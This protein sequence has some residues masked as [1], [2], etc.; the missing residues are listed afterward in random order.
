[1]LNAG[2]SLV[3]GFLAGSTINTLAQHCKENTASQNL[4]F[5][6]YDFYKF[7]PNP[8]TSLANVI[9]KI[10]VVNNIFGESPIQYVP[11]QGF[12][13]ARGKI[14][15]I[16]INVTWT[17]SSLYDFLLC[18]GQCA[19]HVFNQTLH[20]K[21]LDHYQLFCQKILHCPEW[22]TLFSVLEV[23]LREDPALAKWLQKRVNFLFKLYTKH[24]AEG[25]T[26][27]AS[28][29]FTLEN[30]FKDREWK[31]FFTTSYR[32]GLDGKIDLAEA[33]HLTKTPEAPWYPS[34]E[35][36]LE[37][38][39]AF[40]AAQIA[41]KKNEKILETLNQHLFWIEQEKLEKKKPLP[42][43]P[44]KTISLTKRKIAITKSE[45]KKPPL[46]IQE[47]QRKHWVSDHPW[48]CL[49]ALSTLSFGIF[50]L[51]A[52]MMKE[53]TPKTQLANETCSDLYF[54]LVGIANLTAAHL[55]FM[56]QR[57]IDAPSITP[58]LD[59]F[60]NGIPSQILLFE[61]VPLGKEVACSRSLC[62]GWD[63]VS[64]GRL[65]VE[66]KDAIEKNTFKNFQSLYIKNKGEPFFFQRELELIYKDLNNTKSFLE[67]HYKYNETIIE[68]IIDKYHPSQQDQYREIVIKK[69]HLQFL[70]KITPIKDLEELFDQ[71]QK[72]FSYQA[73]EYEP[74]D[75]NELA[76]RIDSM[77]DAVKRYGSSDLKVAIIASYKVFLPYYEKYL[78]GAENPLY[79]A[80]AEKEII[81][82]YASQL[83]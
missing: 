60:Y 13:Q 81:E 25:W 44:V 33:L 28:D 72:D 27:A 23:A 36:E 67:K 41:L 53:S 62:R 6:N 58:C 68:R 77:R 24:L 59:E 14:D 20:W 52:E 65:F 74:H 10:N 43:K 79:V 63:F 66:R 51:L 17:T 82:R 40:Q 37:A 69:K 9:D 39:K 46:L 19:Y 11:G 12:F 55:L 50:Y 15:E 26:L 57:T 76:K 34:K 45:L 7:E 61:N 1:M 8:H 30:Y 48:L 83:Q 21:D 56:V 54:P 70:L 35:K 16:N 64:P 3:D 80:Y 22:E 49:M 42:E 29:R 2:L 32:H 73:K 47:E 4:F 38:E 18:S 75:E 31:Q 71:Y 5:K 78:Q